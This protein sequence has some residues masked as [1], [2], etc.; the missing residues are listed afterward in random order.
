MTDNEYNELL[1]EL[2]EFS[3]LPPEERKKYMNI[4]RKKYPF[5]FD[6]NYSC[7]L[8]TGMEKITYCGVDIT[9][10]IL[11]KYYPER[12]KEEVNNE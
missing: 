7:C 3:S 1:N 9:E 11:K 8:N 10:T 4:K 6:K 5:L 12:L 2:E